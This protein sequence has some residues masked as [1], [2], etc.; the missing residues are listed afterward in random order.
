MNTGDDVSNRTAAAREH[1]EQFLGEHYTWMCGDFDEAVNRATEY[2]SRHEIAI[3]PGKALDLGCGSGIQ[4]I[5]LSTL[6][7]AVTAVDFNAQLLAEL[8]NRDSD[9]RIKTVQAD[10]VKLESCEIH[11]PF[12]VVICMGDTLP[13]LPGKQEVTDLIRYA[14]EHLLAAGGRFVVSFRDQ[15]SELTGIDRAL[16]VRL[17]EN[18]LMLT[19]LEYTPTHLMVHDMLLDRTADGWQFRKSAYPKVRLT[20]NDITTTMRDNG[21]DMVHTSIDRGMTYIVSRKP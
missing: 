5:A 1:Y 3:V 8:R 4:A 6:G 10:L 20:T 9:G 21:L 17:D 7:M 12:D 19:F 11:G 18:R 13:H 14:A 16:P 15:G 2:F